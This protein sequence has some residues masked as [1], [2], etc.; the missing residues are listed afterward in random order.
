[1]Y[2]RLVAGVKQASFG[3][4]VLLAAPPLTCGDRRLIA[5][6]TPH[7]PIEGRYEV[8]TSPAPIED[9]A[10]GAGPV[11]ALEPFDA[12][13]SAGAYNRPALAKLYGGRRARV[14]RGW[15]ERGGAI[16]SETWISPYPSA[17]FRRLEPGTLLLRHIIPR[18]P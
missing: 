9:A 17:D 15:R 12:F 11:E 13:G 4:L 16:E 6:F 7:Q 8:C 10:S 1:M 18:Q 14:A 3:A 2:S 5:L